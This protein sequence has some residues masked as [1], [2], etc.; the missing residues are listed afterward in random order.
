MTTKKKQP[1]EDVYKFPL[2]RLFFLIVILVFPG[3]CN[4]QVTRCINPE[5]WSWSRNKVAADWCVGGLGA[6][7]LKTSKRFLGF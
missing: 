6:L 4:K 1:F 2:K 7:D 3:G 5:P